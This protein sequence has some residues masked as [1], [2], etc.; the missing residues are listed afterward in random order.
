MLTPMHPLINSEGTFNEKLR[1]LKLLGFISEIRA[2]SLYKL[3][4]AEIISNM[5]R[6]KP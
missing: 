1:T 5:E 2:G 6:L 3:N 4:W